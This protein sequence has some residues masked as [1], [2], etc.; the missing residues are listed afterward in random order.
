M[1]KL[2]SVTS[3]ASAA[4]ILVVASL[5][6]CQVVFG[7]LEVDP[8]LDAPGAAGNGGNDGC[9][10]R[11]W[12]CVASALRQCSD[13]QKWEDRATCPEERLCR[14]DLGK[15]VT[16]NEDEY[17]CSGDLS[18]I[19]KCNGTLNGW[20]PVT[21]CPTPGSENLFCAK[22]TDDDTQY[23]CVACEYSTCTGDT[24]INECL[25]NRQKANEH[26]CTG[27]DG[28]C[29]QV[30]NGKGAYCGTC[31]S[32]GNFC[33]GDNIRACIDGMITTITD[34]VAIGE[35]CR[36]TNNVPSCQAQ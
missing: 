13:S 10:P 35:V 15:C 23:E 3:R 30:S 18:A 33:S 7:N 9:K 11:D 29:H 2:D 20:T 19:E 4:A 8:K 26:Q 31:T 24:T 21:S 5:V 16:C 17:H 28:K 6:G 12:N 1:L 34:C 22:K 25:S 32:S 36:V 27:G 14:Q